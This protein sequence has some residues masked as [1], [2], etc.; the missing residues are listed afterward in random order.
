MDIIRT[1]IK[2]R[3]KMLNINKLTIF[4]E[5]QR[6]E[7]LWKQYEALFCKANVHL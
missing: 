5:L 4:E 1:S 2:A 6:E 3:E 7:K